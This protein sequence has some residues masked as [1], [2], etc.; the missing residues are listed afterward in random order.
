MKNSQQKNDPLPS[1]SKTEWEVM[2]PL[3]ETGAMAARDVFAALPTGHKWAYRTVKTMLSRL[4]AKGALTYEQIGNS[5][6][7]RPAVAR[8]QLTRHEMQGFMSRVLGGSAAPLLAGFIED[9]D[10]T[11]EEIERLQRQLDR[12]ANDPRRNDKEA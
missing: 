9:H 12:K 7:Y 1:L 8:D 3:W 2:K 10:L 4:V 11:D 6:L 5:Y